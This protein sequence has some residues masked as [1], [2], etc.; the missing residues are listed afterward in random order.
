MAASTI[1][2]RISAGRLIAVHRGVYAVGHLPRLPLARVA[3]AVLACGPDAALSHGSAAT[4]WGMSGRW[5]E[6]FQ[7]TVIRG[8]RRPKGIETHRSG[9]LTRADV[10]RHHG[11]R[12]T[13]AER[14]LLD[15]APAWTRRRLTRAVNDAR[16][17]G[18]IHLAALRDVLDRF[19]RHPGA[20]ALRPHALTARGGPTR[21]ELEDAFLRFARRHELPAPLV[22]TRVNGREVDALYPAQRLIIELDGWDFHSD[23]MAFEDDRAR[24]AAALRAGYATLRI[25]WER[26]HDDPER[27]AATIRQVL[28]S[29]TS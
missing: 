22:N 25:T 2:S 28:R 9:A 27:E 6:P 26:L 12:V 10:R 24:D 4:L 8:D 18:L 16:R 21:S 3:A 11:I 1:T 29:R 17:A 5:E 7:V 13:S 20:A 19:P 15:V 23:R 14:T